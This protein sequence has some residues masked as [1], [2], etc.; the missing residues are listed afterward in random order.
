[1]PAQW[2]DPNTNRDLWSIRLTSDCDLP[3]QTITNRH[4]QMD[5][6]KRGLT[7]LVVDDDLSV[8][9]VRQLLLE[10]LGHRVLVADS[11]EKAIDLFVSKAIDVVILDYLMPGMDGEETARAI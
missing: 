3:N 5:A 10:A 6:A 2:I 1:M 11:G 4:E 9:E 8:L 7:I